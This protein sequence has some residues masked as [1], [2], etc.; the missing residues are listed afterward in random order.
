MSRMVLFHLDESGSKQP[1]N[2]LKST[3]TDT[4]D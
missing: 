1:I 2:E 3:V 4:V